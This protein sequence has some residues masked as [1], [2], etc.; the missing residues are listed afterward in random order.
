MDDEVQPSAI[1]T[2]IVHRPSSIVHRPSSL[3]QPPGI[4]G[5]GGG[6]LDVEV[7][8]HALGQLGA[9]LAGTGAEL[10]GVDRLAPHDVGV[11]AVVAVVAF[12]YASVLHAEL[13]VQ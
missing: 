11:F 12:A 2:S 5:P 10:W 9:Q 3:L 1:L 7:A 8:P 13:A 6:R 4:H